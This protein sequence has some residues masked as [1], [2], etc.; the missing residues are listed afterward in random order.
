MRMMIIVV[1]GGL[2]IAAAYPATAGPCTT[3]VPQQNAKTND[4]GSGPTPGY[5]GATTNQAKQDTSAGGTEVTGTNPE[6]SGTKLMN[7]TVGSKAASSED[8]R[9]QN[10]GQL[11]AAQQAAGVKPDC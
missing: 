2:T 1:A 7:E 9:K 6:Q 10:Q 4:A 5:T 3:G 11:T 8:V